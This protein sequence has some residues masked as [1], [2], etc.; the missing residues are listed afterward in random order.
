M[1]VREHRTPGHAMRKPKQ[2]PFGA[3]FEISRSA[4]QTNFPITRVEQRNDD[5][6][7]ILSRAAR[8]G[9]PR[10]QSARARMPRVHAAPR[11]TAHPIGQAKITLG[12]VGEPT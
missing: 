6:E 9:K 5:G 1:F 10:P 12:C 11:M 3:R 2:S 4:G 7:L 8:L